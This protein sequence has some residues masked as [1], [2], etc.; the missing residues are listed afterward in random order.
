MKWSMD[1][2]VTLA[3]VPLVVLLLPFLPGVVMADGI[4]SL[5]IGEGKW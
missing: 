4:T 2:A 5:E 1:F 3:A